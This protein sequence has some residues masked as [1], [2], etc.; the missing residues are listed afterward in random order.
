MNT[1]S[2]ITPSK[3]RVR[4]DRVPDHEDGFVVLDFTEEGLA[5]VSVMLQGLPHDDLLDILDGLAEQLRAIRPEIEDDRDRTWQPGE[6]DRVFGDMC[7]EGFHYTPP[8]EDT[9]TREAVAFTGIRYKGLGDGPWRRYDWR[10][11]GLTDAD[12]E[13]RILDR[14]HEQAAED[15]MVHAAEEAE[16]RRDSDGRR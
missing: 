8:E 1:N 10:A 3:T 4:F 12:A 14:M 5:Y 13:V 9:N 11:R 7:V 16:W 2:Q 6:H 15:A